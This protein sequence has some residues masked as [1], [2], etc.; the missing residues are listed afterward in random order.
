M[1]ECDGAVARRHHDFEQHTLQSSI[2]ANNTA[3]VGNSSA[4]LYLPV[5]AGTLSGADNVV[6]AS[7]I[8]SP[9]PGVITITTDPKLGPLAF[10]GGTTRTH[11][12]LPGSPA[13]GVGNNNAM[14]TND[15]RGDGYPRT[16]G[17]NA[18]VTSA[19]SSSIRFSQT[20]SSSTDA[21]IHTSLTIRP[22]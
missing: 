14:R 9:P 5:G 22:I 15:Q 17:P 4:D 6:I 13:L 18:S 16:T 8:V 2:I 12:L 11:A 19:L 1:V 7:N 21:A 10:N 3:G 20:T